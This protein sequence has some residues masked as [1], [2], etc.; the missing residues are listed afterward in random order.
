MTISDTRPP[1]GR[2]PTVVGFP[3]GFLWGAATAAY[4]IEGAVAEDGRTPSIWDTFCRIPGAVL[5]GDTGD[6]ACDHYHRMPRRRRADAR[7]RPR[8]RTAS[9]WRGRGCGPTAAP[10]NPAGSTSTTGSSTS[11]SPPASRR[12]SRSTTGT[13]RRR[14]RTRAAGPTATPPTASPTTPLSVHDALGDRVPTWTTLNEPWC[15]AFLGYAGGQHAP[16]RREG[17]AG[18][19]RRAPPAARARPGRRRAARAA[20]PTTPSGITPQPHRAPTRRP[21]RPGRPWTPR[22]GSTAC[23]T[24]SSSTRSSA[25]ATRPTCSRTP[26][27]STWQGEPWPTSCATATWRSSRTP[28]DVLGVNYY[29]GDAVSAHPH[30]RRRRGRQRPARRGRRGSP[31]RGHRA[32]HLPQPRAAASPTWAGRSSPRACTGL[33]RAPARRL[34]APPMLR[35]RERR[36][37]RRRPSAPTAGARPRPD[38]LPRRPPARR[39]PRRSTQGVDVRGYFVWSLLDNFEWAYGYAKRFGLVYVDYDTQ[40]RMPKESAALVRRRGGHRRVRVGLRT[41]HARPVPGATDSRRGGAR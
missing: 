23:T 13:C 8:R 20:A 28:I 39:A 2:P 41:E 36:G 22:G 34:P 19:G 37:L 9:R 7:A 32:R 6:V 14:S 18:A 16:G 33:L 12:G 4:Q 5:D 40:Q 24:G 35:H 3:D 11:C 27:T 17:V 25:A 31:V 10:V 38:R 1:S 26:R 29:H 15:S 30:D 21:D